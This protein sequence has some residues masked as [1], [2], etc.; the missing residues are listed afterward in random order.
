MTSISQNIDTLISYPTNISHNCRFLPFFDGKVF[1]WIRNTKKLVHHRILNWLG[2]KFFLI[3]FYHY[4]TAFLYLTQKSYKTKNI[5]YRSFTHC[6]M[7]QIFIWFVF[8][9]LFW[10]FNFHSC[11]LSSNVQSFEDQQFQMF[12]WKHEAFHVY[13]CIHGVVFNISRYTV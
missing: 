13:V 8:Q 7:H 12:Y 5:T 9:L 1:P 10:W 6:L 3:H 4:C 2:K 11:F